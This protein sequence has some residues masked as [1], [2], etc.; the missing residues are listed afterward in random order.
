[1]TTTTSPRLT[2]S[3]RLAFHLQS[4]LVALIDLQM[5][6]K[7]AHWNVVGPN[8][9]SLH[10]QL[11]EIVGEVRALSDTIA[12]RMRALRATPDGRVATIA[13]TTALAPMPAGEQQTVDVVEFMTARIDTVVSGL[14]ATLEEID[15]EDPVTADLVHAV[16]E[17]LEKHAWLLGSENIRAE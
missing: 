15:A 5:Q 8:F 1:M 4:A 10:L 13:A 17:S 6:G 2:A 16:I 7:Q 14:R 9:R 11:D 12:E 3:T